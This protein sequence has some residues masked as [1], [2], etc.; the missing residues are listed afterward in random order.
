VVMSDEGAPES[1]ELFLKYLPVSATEKSVRTHFSECKSVQSVRLSINKDSGECKG[2]AWLVLGDRAEADWLIDE[3]NSEP[4]NEMDGRHME[5]SNASVS[6]AWKSRPLTY[7]KSAGAGAAPPCRYGAGCLRPDCTFKHPPSWNPSADSKMPAKDGEHFASRVI[8]RYG[9]AC[10]HPKCFFVHPDGRHY[11]DAGGE[12]RP[13]DWE[14]P[15]CGANVFAGKDVCFKCGAAKGSAKT[16]KKEKDDEIGIVAIAESSPLGT[17]TINEDTTKKKKLKKRKSIV[18][19]SERT[20][21]DAADP[22]QDAPRAKKKRRKQKALSP[23]PEEVTFSDPRRKKRPVEIG[24]I[25]F[26]HPGH[27]EPCDKLCCASFLGNFWDLGSGNLRLTTPNSPSELA[28]SNAE[29]AF[30]ALKFWTDADQFAPLSGDGAFQLKRSLGGKE[31]FKYGGYGSNWAGMMAVLR[32]KFSQE[33]MKQGLLLTQDAF[34]LE[35]NS[36]EGRDKVWSDNC[37]GD[38]TNWLGLQLMIVR[39]ELSGKSAWTRY[40]GKY[41]ELD[42]G[43]AKGADSK[44][45]WQDAVQKACTLLTNALTST[46]PVSHT[47][48]LPLC[49]KPT[50]NGQANEYCSRE[51]RQE[52]QAG[53]APSAGGGPECMRAACGKP[54]WNGQPSEYCSRAHRQQTQADQA[55]AC[56]LHGCSKAAWTAKPNEYCS[57]AH[58]QAALAA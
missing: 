47:C 14:C 33:T 13:G 41:I 31:D 43:K 51:H 38:G 49:G 18:E 45:E 16:K 52:A 50:W 53:G 46:A 29:S 48:L 37:K 34:L 25:G 7:S 57:R 36:V 44:N 22:E 8:C 54:T 21:P 27:D 42:T 56:S 4:F 10:K 28:F 19:A 55:F 17:Q 35:H 32:V 9:Q 40:I 3:W 30:Q 58:R 24:I 15:G 11:D 39:D 23:K 5:I 26:Y 12:V 1:H 2:M 20:T 6:A